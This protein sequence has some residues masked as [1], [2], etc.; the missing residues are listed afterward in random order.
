MGGQIETLAAESYRVIAIDSRG[1]GK[2][3]NTA[4]ALT[5][6]M[7]SDDVVGVIVLIVGAVR[8]SR[9][10]R[11]GRY[12]PTGYGPGSGPPR[13][14]GSRVRLREPFSENRKKV[15]SASTVP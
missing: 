10:N 14:A 4:P 11:P 1:N 6:E 8:R 12:A 15:S 3:S 7:M 2:S 13:R 9:A 5:Y